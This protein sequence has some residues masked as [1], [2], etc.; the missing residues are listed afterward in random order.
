MLGLFGGK[1]KTTQPQTKQNSLETIKN[2]GLKISDLEEKIV[3]G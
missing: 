2:L 3:F 1:K